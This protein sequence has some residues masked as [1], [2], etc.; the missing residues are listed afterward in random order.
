MRQVRFIALAALVFVGIA[1]A[2]GPV[3]AGA[4][5][6]VPFVYEPDGAPS[7][8]YLAGQFNNWSTDA[9]PMEEVDGR[10]EVTLL[11]PIGRYQYKFVADGN[12]ITDETADDFHPD[13]YGG[14]N[15]VVVVDERFEDVALERGDGVIT[16]FQLGHGRHA[17]EVSVARDGTVAFRTR[18]WTGDISDAALVIEG[19]RGSTS[20]PME[21]VDSDGLFDYL[22]AEVRTAATG[23]R[24]DYAFTLTDGD[25][26]LWLGP[27]GFAETGEAAGTFVFD[28]EAFPVFATPD[29][30]KDGIFYQIFPERFANGD[31][32]NDQDFSEW[33]YEGL[34]D[35]PAS[36][37]T[38]DVYFHFVD[39]WYDV[40]GLSKSP[41]RTDGKPDWNS[42]YGGDIAGVRE[43]LDY[44]ADLG[45]TVIYFNPLFE[46]QS[47]H[48][49]DAVSY[50]RLDPHFG[51]NQEFAD[52]V[53]A[54]HERGIRVIM[55]LAYN[56]TG[57]TFWAFQDT[58]ERGPESPYWDWYEW[59]EWPL[60]G[61]GVNP[62][63]NAKDYYDCWW[64]F[65]W[66]P[67]LN[68]DLAR[69]NPDEQG[70]KDITDA[71]VN[72]PV[73]EHLLA[74]TVYWLTEADVDGF[75]LD[76]AG[77]VPFWFWEL[78]RERVRTVDPDAYIVG[79]L[80]GPSPEWVNGRYYDA[81]MN[82][83]YFRD[84]VLGFIASG[85]MDAAEF[86]RA[87]APGRLIYPDEGVRAQMNLLGSHDTP[88]FLTNCGGDVDRLK[89]AMLF[90]MTYVGAPTIYYGDEIAMEGG[91]DPDCRRP[92]RWTWETEPVRVDVH[93]HVRRLAAIRTSHPLFSR[94]DFETLV[95]DGR[96]FAYRRSLDDDVAYVVLNAGP[97]A[98]SVEVPVVE[99]HGSVVEALSGSIVPVIAGPAGASVAVELEPMS[100]AVL[101]PE[102]D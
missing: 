23:T 40:E 75:R 67:N 59:R 91:G 71:Q 99:D 80:W 95:S 87:L 55:D 46:S 37:K 66:M 38:N 63:P 45:V 60:P 32:S 73:V 3:H 47:N 8:V 18:V 39:D 50:M 35:L 72:W 89:L 83:A 79:E 15:S 90:S 57:H 88:R 92:F 24:F 4:L 53:D 70:V 65:G 58:R 25:A 42:F 26:E 68:F 94:G 100:G 1:T 84:P 7:Q 12:W 33:Y 20:V 30:A 27:G 64:G 86:D 48:K 10:F 62:P 19:A 34:T 44:L 97:T 93:D 6:Q 51:T 54:A 52:F 29:W 14:Q 78:F 31:A 76:V 102:G 9:T 17:W 96:V 16:T 77:E 69:D 28:A 101:L 13:G 22:E 36:G 11:L 74:A 56:H 98:V 5:K 82:Y 41:Y 21:R 49:Y 43:N 81:V 2:A 61:E 85:D